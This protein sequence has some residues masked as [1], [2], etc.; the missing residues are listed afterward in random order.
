MT[1]TSTWV[2]GSVTAMPRRVSA[3][4]HL[5][6]RAQLVRAAPVGGVADRDVVLGDR[7]VGVAHGVEADVGAQH[8]PVAADAAGGAGSACPTPR[9]RR[10]A[11][12]RRRRGR[13]GGPARA[14]RGRP[15]PPARSRGPPPTTARRRSS[16]RRAPGGA[17]RRGCAWRGAGA[18]PWAGRTGTVVKDQTNPVAFS[19]GHSR[20]GLSPAGRRVRRPTPRGHRQAC[21][22]NTGSGSSATPNAASTPAAISR[23]S[24]TSWAVVP[25]P[26]FVERE[27][28]LA[29]DRD[30]R[31]VAVP[32]REAGPLDQP[33]RR[34]LDRPV[35]LREA[36]HA[37]LGAEPLARRAP[38]ARR[39]RRRRARGS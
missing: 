37:R 34:R 1:A 16:G 28:V 23:A 5:P 25:A 9:A 32:A 21:P 11:C 15:A 12:A 2:R 13:P 38:P 36:R 20:P 27:R 14:P 7:A 30:R 33:R 4:E 8:G 6:L 35:G 22:A 31:R 39:T 19:F 18:P 24:A 3:E 17:G 10:A 29:R 26:R